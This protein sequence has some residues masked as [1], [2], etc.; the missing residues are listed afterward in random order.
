MKSLILCEGKTDAILLSYY[1]QRT[2]GWQYRKQPKELQFS[3]DSQKGET[4]NWYYK[5]G[6]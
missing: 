2:C 3:F 5:N 6:S 4:G 1:L